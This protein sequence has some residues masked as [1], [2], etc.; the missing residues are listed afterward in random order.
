[1]RQI[2]STTELICD[3]C[4]K[5]VDSLATIGIQKDYEYFDAYRHKADL[6]SCCHKKLDEFLTSC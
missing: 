2:T 4:K 6:C 3:R 5:I 1:M